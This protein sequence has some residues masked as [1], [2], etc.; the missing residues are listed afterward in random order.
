MVLFICSMFSM[1]RIR[2]KYNMVMTRSS[3][4]EGARE[5]KRAGLQLPFRTDNHGWSGIR[6]QLCIL[7][8]A[9]KISHAQEKE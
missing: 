9:W 3:R 4:D 8:C 6:Q 2:K 5:G 1:L 7:A